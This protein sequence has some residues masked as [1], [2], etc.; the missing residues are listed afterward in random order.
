[1]TE[2]WTDERVQALSQMW[3]KGHSVNAIARAIGV[4]RG[5]IAGKV[6]RLGL[7]GRKSPLPEQPRLVAPMRDD[8][9]PDTSAAAETSLPP[10]D[11]PPRS[12]CHWPLWP[13]KAGRRHPKYGRFCGHP[14]EGEGQSYCAKHAAKA[15]SRAARV[16]EAAE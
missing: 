7:P 14:V 2:T 8:I 16:P 15:Y 1:M 4:S 11:F 13:N 3:A 9:A 6:S 5:A 10:I 12:A